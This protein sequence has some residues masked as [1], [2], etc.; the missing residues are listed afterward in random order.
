MLVFLVYLGDFIGTLSNVLFAGILVLSAISAFTLIGT[1]EY[2]SGLNGGN[3]VLLTWY[4]DFKKLVKVYLVVLLMFVVIPSQKTFYV[5][6]AAYAGTVVAETPEAKRI[7][8]KAMSALESK[9]DS[10]IEKPEPKKADK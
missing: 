4:A 10:L 3:G 2:I 5:M 6:V 7:F 1:S 9:I 8:D